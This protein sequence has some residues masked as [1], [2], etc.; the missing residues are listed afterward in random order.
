MDR[1]REIANILARALHARN[2]GVEVVRMQGLIDAIMADEFG[3]EFHW[4]KTIRIA[5]KAWREA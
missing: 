1:E 2:A 4:L 5:D 3:F